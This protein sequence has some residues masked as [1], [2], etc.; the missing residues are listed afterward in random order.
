M[1]VFINQV[2]NSGE[3]TNDNVETTTDDS[4]SSM[5]HGYENYEIEFVARNSNIGVVGDYEQAADDVSAVTIPSSILNIHYCNRI[6]EPKSRLSVSIDTELVDIH[7]DGTVPSDTEN[8]DGNAVSFCHHVIRRSFAFDE[9]DDDQKLPT[10]VNYADATDQDDSDYDS[11]DQDLLENS[12]E[13]NDTIPLGL[14]ANTLETSE[15]SS[16]MPDWDLEENSLVG[17]SSSYNVAKL[18]KLARLSFKLSR[19]IWWTTNKSVCNNQRRR[20][21][22]R[23]VKASF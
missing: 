13:G 18:D 6:M 14:V 2:M 20:Q 19:P 17:V 3:A 22:K 8:D 16:Q 12:M 5:L 11:F 21:R 15:R 23:S 1:K 10:T 4:S 9:G 7:C